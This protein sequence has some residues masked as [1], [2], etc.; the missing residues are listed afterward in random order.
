MGKV[1]VF[2]IVFLSRQLIWM[3]TCMLGFYGAKNGNCIWVGAFGGGGQ[4]ARGEMC[5]PF[6]R[7][8]SISIFEVR[9]CKVFASLHVFG[10]REHINVCF[11]HVAGSV[12]WKG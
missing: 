3:F 4:R 7:E 12:G 5:S 6:L 10:G 2:S 8:R 9:F 11:A 1:G